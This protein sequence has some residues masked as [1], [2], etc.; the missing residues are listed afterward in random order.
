MPTAVQV[1]LWVKDKDSRKVIIMEPSNL[2]DLD[3]MKLKEVL[4][5]VKKELLLVVQ[6]EIK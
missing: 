4:V 2:Q 6:Q 3:L 5:Q 1:E